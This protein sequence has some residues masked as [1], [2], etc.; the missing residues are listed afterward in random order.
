MVIINLSYKLACR[1]ENRLSANVERKSHG[2]RAMYICTILSY[3]HIPA[4]DGDNNVI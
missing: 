1:D 3:S 2:C 4:C